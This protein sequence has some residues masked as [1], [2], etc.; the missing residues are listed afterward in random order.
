M[1]PTETKTQIKEVSDDTAV[2]VCGEED[3]PPTVWPSEKL[4]GWVP[5][6]EVLDFDLGKDGWTEV[7]V[8]TRG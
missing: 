8:M 3:L 4:A 2:V 6:G 5:T 1:S 7:W